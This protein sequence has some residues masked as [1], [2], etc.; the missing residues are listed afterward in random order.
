MQVRKIGASYGG[1]LPV[2]RHGRRYDDAEG[3]LFWGVKCLIKSLID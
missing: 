3:V 1:N 2:Y